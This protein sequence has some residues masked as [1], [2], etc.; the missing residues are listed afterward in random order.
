MPKIFTSSIRITTPT[1][2]NLVSANNTIVHQL[3]ERWYL[4]NVNAG[5]NTNK[6]Y[7]IAVLRVTQP[8]GAGI[9]PRTVYEVRTGYGRIGAA[10]SD[11]KALIRRQHHTAV[12][13]AQQ[14]VRTK[15]TKGYERRDVPEGES[16]P[17]CPDWFL[18]ASDEDH[19]HVPIGTG[20]QA[21]RVTSPVKENK[22]P[23]KLER[24][25]AP[26]AI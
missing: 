18:N 11:G 4:T 24:K 19:S 22:K 1:L 10:V 13:A 6:H 16:A 15:L 2:D 20:R 8:G 5:T 26:W 25:N 23:D 21:V 12:A 9:S 14:V 7:F 17:N 3:Y